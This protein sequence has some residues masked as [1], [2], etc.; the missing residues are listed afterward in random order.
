MNLTLAV[1]LAALT[2]GSIDPGDDATGD[3]NA[4]ALLVISAHWEK[5]VPR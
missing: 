1:L 5:A 4:S 2:S 3:E